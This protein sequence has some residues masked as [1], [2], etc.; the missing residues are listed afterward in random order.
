[1]ALEVGWP[2]GDIVE[3]RFTDSS[4]QITSGSAIAYIMWSAFGLLG[5]ILP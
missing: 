3:C 4:P 5:E 1:M 2:A